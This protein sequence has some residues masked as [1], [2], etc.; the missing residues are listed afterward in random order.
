MR[1]VVVRINSERGNPKI[2]TI[3]KT[4]VQNLHVLIHD[5]ANGG[6]TGKEKFC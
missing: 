5:G 1:F 3:S 6:A 2:L 4:I